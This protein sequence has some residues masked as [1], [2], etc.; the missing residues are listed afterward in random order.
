MYVCYHLMCCACHL[1]DVTHRVSSCCGKYMWALGYG[2]HLLVLKLLN[3]KMNLT[4]SLKQ[5]AMK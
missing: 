3:L 4:N 1:D 5:T 2:A